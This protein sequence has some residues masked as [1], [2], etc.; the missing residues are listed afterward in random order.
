[1]TPAD[2]PL[3]DPGEGLPASPGRRRFAIAAGILMLILILVAL[4]W[5]A[6]TNTETNEDPGRLLGTE[7]RRGAFLG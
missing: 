7:D 4:A 1:M 5:F 6:V 2:D 3:D